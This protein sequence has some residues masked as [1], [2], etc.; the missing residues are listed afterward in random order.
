MKLNC[1][2][3]VL[4][5]SCAKVLWDYTYRQTNRRWWVSQPDILAVNKG[6]RRDVVI[7]MAIVSDGKI[8][9]TE[10]KTLKKY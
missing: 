2:N 6:L 5:N 1:F 10:H 7:D 3:S 8:R 4:E 9:E